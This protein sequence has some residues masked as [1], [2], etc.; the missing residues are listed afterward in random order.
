MIRRLL[1]ANRGEIACRVFRTARTMGVRTVAVYA[2]P[3]RNALHVRQADEA[4]ALGGVSAAESYLRGDAVIAAALKAGADAIHPGYGYLAERADFAAA[5]VA[6]GLIF[7]G[8]DADAMAVMGD[9]ASAK[10]RMQEVGVACLPGYDGAAQDDETLT[11]AALALGFPVLVK[12]AAGGGG[13]G[14]RLVPTAAEFGDALAAARREALAAFGDARVLLER[15]VA[16][17][18]HIE[19]QV[20]GD[21]HGALVHLGERDCSTQRRRQKLLE[22]CPA[23]GLTAEQRD[24]L[25]ADALRAAGAV[26]YVGAGTVEFLLDANGRHHFLEMN[27]RLQVEHPVTEACYGVDLVEWQLRVAAGEPLPKTQDELHSQGH[28]LEV[29]LVAED[30]ALGFAPQT[31]SI[32]HWRPD[33]ALARIDDGVREG[34]QV[35]SHCDSLLAKLIVHAQDRTLALQAMRVALERT[36]LLGLAHNGAWLRRLLDDD[37]LRNAGMTTEAIDAD[38]GAPADPLAETEPT[39]EHWALAAA[40]LAGAHLG[41]RRPASVARFSLTLRYGP[42]RRHARIHLQ[43]GGADVRLD[44]DDTPIALRFVDADADRHCVRVGIDD[45]ESDVTVVCQPGSVHL[46]QGARA[47]RFDEVLPGVSI[48]IIGD[49]TRLRATVAGR[50]TA[51]SAQPGDAVRK[52]QA[53][54]CVEAMKMELWVAALRDGVVQ[55]LHVQVGDSVAAG[56]VLIS[57]EEAVA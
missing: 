7:V 4:C 3:D 27:T 19:V 11:R 20:F 57:L 49:D 5:C 33:G 26:S 2:D 18:R 38:S 37:R 16:H 55:D 32:V 8:P 47:L 42:T 51:V 14:I 1:V 12:A 46:A 44:A 23:P 43:T 24:A 36:P 9:K 53:L 56:Q 29:R 6:A 30:P 35:G 40:L 31:G 10:R 22:E 41:G 25:R 13:R 21:R 45:V 50:V 17:A 48:P 28:A 34:D 39:S 15:P 52:G 54:V